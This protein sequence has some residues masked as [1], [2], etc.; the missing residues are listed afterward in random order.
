MRA[1]VFAVM[2]M[3]GVPTIAMSETPPP[4]VAQV[5]FY[6]EGNRL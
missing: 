4:P 3:S 6:Q 1:V 5:E 2:A